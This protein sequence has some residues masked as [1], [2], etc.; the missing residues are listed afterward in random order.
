MAAS[1]DDERELQRVAKVLAEN[2]STFESLSAP[3]DCTLRD[4][5]AALLNFYQVASSVAVIPETQELL[6]ELP[7]PDD[8]L[9]EGLQLALE[10]FE[11][12]RILR[13]GGKDAGSQESAE[14]RDAQVFMCA[15]KLGNA[16]YWAQ[17]VH[18]VRREGAS[19]ENA[20]WFVLF[21]FWDHLGAEILESLQV[22]H[23]LNNPIS[24]FA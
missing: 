3:S 17:C 9:A 22:L 12:E 20:V 21:H 6:P 13:F 24:D 8:T 10:L 7:E 2:V 5:R 4:L 14:E 16:R 11:R 23:T 1:Q 18:H 19:V 15:I